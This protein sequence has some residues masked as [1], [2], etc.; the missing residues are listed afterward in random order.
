MSELNTEIRNA[1][2]TM[3]VDQARQLLRDALKNPDAETYYLASLVALN[4]KQ[5]QEFLDKAIE[6]DPFF[7]E[8]HKELKKL[9]KPVQTASQKPA[10][11]TT[12]APH[13]TTNVAQSVSQPQP[14]TPTG[15][16]QQAVN[17]ASSKGWEPQNVSNESVNFNLTVHNGTV[18]GL[19]SLGLLIM[20]FFGEQGILLWI[21]IAIIWAVLTYTTQSQRRVTFNNK[22]DG[23]VEILDDKGSN[24]QATSLTDL[25]EMSVK[26]IGGTHHLVRKTV[27]QIGMVFGTSFLAAIVWA[28]IHTIF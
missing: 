13:A 28:I 17:W 10:S 8:A 19:A 22:P 27:T 9:N 1:I 15:L 25:D 14:S 4:D 2:D 7:D 5:K 11:T 3:N 16:F 20:G 23:T 6:L 12:V 21:P 18:I 24:W 26:I